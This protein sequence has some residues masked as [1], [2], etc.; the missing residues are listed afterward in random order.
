VAYTYQTEDTQCG[1]FFSQARHFE[2][3]VFM[4]AKMKKGEPCPQWTD[5]TWGQA[6][7]EAGLLG[8]GLIESGISKNDRIGLFSN[9]RPR[10]D[11]ADQAIQGAGG[12]GVPIYPTSTDSQLAFILNNCGAKTVIAGDRELLAQALRVKAQVP[13]ME[14]IVCLSPAPADNDPCIIDYDGL[15]RKGADSPSAREQFDQR[16]NEL[17]STDTGAIIY[18]SGTTGNPKGVVLSQANFKA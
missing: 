1:L 4:R 3:D 10:W 14:F 6:A 2:N 11:I 8:A 7:R 17:K 18:T 5:I 15:M 12:I 13:C 16:R 9:N